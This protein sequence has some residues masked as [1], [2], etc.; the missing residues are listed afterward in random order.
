MH[1]DEHLPKWR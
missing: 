1:L